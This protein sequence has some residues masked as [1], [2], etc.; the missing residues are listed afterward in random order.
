MVARP[1]KLLRDEGVV[2]SNPATLTVK[3][4]VRGLI[5]LV[6]QAPEWFGV[7]KRVPTAGGPPWKARSPGTH[8]VASGAPVDVAGQRVTMIA[9]R[10]T[11]ARAAELPD[12]TFSCAL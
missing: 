3:Y 9:S 4:Q 6:D 11:V 2:G 10:C 7:R 8:G 1:P 5:Q 12:S